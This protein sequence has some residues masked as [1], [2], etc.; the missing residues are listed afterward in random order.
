MRTVLM[1]LHRPYY[2]EAVGTREPVSL[3][4]NRRAPSIVA[5]FDSA[6]DTIDCLE[7]TYRAA[8]LLTTRYIII[9]SN[10]FAGAVS[11]LYFSS[12]HVLTRCVAQP[13]VALS[14]C[15]AH[16]LLQ[17]DPART[18]AAG[19]MFI[20]LPTGTEQLSKGIT[21]PGE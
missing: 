17:T 1:Q 7:R 4:H 9:W 3:A 10:A 11:L 2:S 13:G 6:S 21:D 20:P 19:K 14:P 16:A 12:W 15:V 8:P 18:T 5:T